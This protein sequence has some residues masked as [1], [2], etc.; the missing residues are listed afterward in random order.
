M[1]TPLIVILLVILS[2]SCR[3]IPSPDREIVFEQC[4]P[5]FVFTSSGDIDT[6]ESVCFCRDYKRSLGYQGAV[7]VVRDEPIIHCQKLIGSP[8][9]EYEQDVLF[10]ETLRFDLQR[11]MNRGR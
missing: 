5:L 9:E 11:A 10:T 6:K 7:G 3:S 4:S 1:R 2:A 8:P